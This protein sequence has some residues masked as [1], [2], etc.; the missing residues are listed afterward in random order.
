[1]FSGAPG[2]IS[3]GSNWW[4]KGDVVSTGPPIER[5]LTLEVSKYILY[6]DRIAIVQGIYS[7]VI[8]AVDITALANTCFE[9]PEVRSPFSYIP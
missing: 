4:L 2:S 5:A 1:M 3:H 9:T 7:H 6:E 8:L